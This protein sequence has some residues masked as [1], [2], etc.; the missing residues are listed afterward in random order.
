MGVKTAHEPA[1]R[2]LPE[3]LRAQTERLL[4]VAV[5][6]PLIIVA[7]DLL[8]GG[9]MSSVIANFVTALLVT[10]YSC[11]VAWMSFR[12]VRATDRWRD[13]RAMTSPRSLPRRVQA[14]EGERAA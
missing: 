1:V 3:P 12:L 10:A 13:A 2:S 4:R 8:L 6:A 7:W 9:L 14:Q 5:L 11:S